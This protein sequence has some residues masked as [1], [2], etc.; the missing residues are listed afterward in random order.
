MTRRS[1]WFALP[2]VAALVSV[3]VHRADAQFISFGV[4]A[5]ASLSTF[6]GDLAKDAKNNTGFIAGAFVRV[7]ALGFAV[8]PG[9]YYTTK[10]AKG[11]DFGLTPG[12]AKLGYIQIPIVIRLHMGPLY[13]GAGP[14][15]GFKLGCKFTFAATASSGSQDCADATSTTAGPKSIEYSGILE[16][17]LNFGKFSLGGRADVGITNAIE[18]IKVNNVQTANFRT[19]TVSIVAAIRF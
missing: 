5:G 4:M 17:G 10:S 16:A 12:T 11:V 18:A 3:P 1:R 7:G 19:R 9:V 14:A 2:I 15:I 8:Q 6:T 13:V